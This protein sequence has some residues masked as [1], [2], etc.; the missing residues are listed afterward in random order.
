MYVCMREGVCVHMCQGVCVHMREGV[1]VRMREGVCVHVY[2]LDAYRVC[3]NPYMFFW[4]AHW[5]DAWV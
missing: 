5:P 1:C 3:N 2:I 4:Q